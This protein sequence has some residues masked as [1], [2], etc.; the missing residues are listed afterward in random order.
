MADKS[1]LGLEFPTHMLTVEGVKIAEF[2]AAVAQK[3]DTYQIKAIYRDVDAAQ[4]AGYE[5]IPIPPTFPTGFAFWSGAGLYGIVNA[6]GADVTKLLHSEEEYEYFAP[7]KA[8]DV[9]TCKMKVADMY[10]RGKK[11]RKGWYFEMTVLETELFNERGEL[12]LRARTTFM[13]R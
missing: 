3:D 9:I 10:E 7:I 6:V 8:G 13:E 11:E 2:A 12:V 4:E 5:N 1:K